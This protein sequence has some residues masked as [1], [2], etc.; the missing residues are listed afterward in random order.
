MASK[1]LSTGGYTRKIERITDQPSAKMFAKTDLSGLKKQ[2]VPKKKISKQLS[3]ETECSEFLG[4]KGFVT[5]R[6]KKEPEELSRAD[7]AQQVLGS[8]GKDTD[9]AFARDLGEG[10]LSL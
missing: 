4:G 10:Y 8:L 1:R 2:P 3:M 7:R 5:V 6:T 9:A